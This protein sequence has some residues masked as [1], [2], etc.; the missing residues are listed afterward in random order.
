MLHSL[1]TCHFILQHSLCTEEHKYLYANK[2][3]V[4]KYLDNWKKIFLALG[5]MNVEK[6]GSR[7][8]RYIYIFKVKELKF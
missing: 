5:V 3:L 8:T 1:R 4:N 7:T 6:D 2:I